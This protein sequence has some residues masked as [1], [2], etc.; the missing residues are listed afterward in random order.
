MAITKRKNEGFELITINADFDN[1]K[2]KGTQEYC[3]KY[4]VG[5]YSIAIFD[6]SGNII[7]ISQST[8]GIPRGKVK[9]EDL[10]EYVKELIQRGE[11]KQNNKGCGKDSE[12]PGFDCGS[13]YVGE[14]VFCLNCQKVNRN[15]KE[16]GE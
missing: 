7:A 6:T 8:C 3:E 13:Y 1:L 9:K 10:I 2:I 5:H 12:V 4:D 11:L 15:T 16:R 14:L